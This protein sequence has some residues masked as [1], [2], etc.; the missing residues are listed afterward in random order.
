MESR[1]SQGL[2]RTNCCQRGQSTATLH[3]GFSGYDLECQP[4][5][6]LFRHLNGQFLSIHRY[7]ASKHVLLIGDLSNRFLD[8]DTCYRTFSQIQVL[9]GQENN[10]GE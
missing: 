6:L 9:I 2:S 3:G 7:P 10:K 4:R 8:T 1:R 5:S